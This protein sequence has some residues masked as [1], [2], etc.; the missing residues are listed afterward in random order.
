MWIYFLF[1][2]KHSAKASQSYSV[3]LHFLK[4]ST[5]SAPWRLVVPETFSATKQAYVNIAFTVFYEIRN[6][7]IK[8]RPHCDCCHWTLQL[9]YRRTP[10]AE[11]VAGNKPPGFACVLYS[12]HQKRFGGTNQAW[13][14]DA[15]SSSANQ[16]AANWYNYSDRARENTRQ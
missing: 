6:G 5:L 11:S 12:K 16:S 15:D 10:F 8:K 2:E 13:C 14:R 9:L 7:S 3:I 1:Y 4:T